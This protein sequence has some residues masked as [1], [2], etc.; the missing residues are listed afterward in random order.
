MVTICL[1]SNHSNPRLCPNHWCQRSWSGMVLWWPTRPSTINTKRIKSP[2]HHRVLEY[3]SRK[4]RDTWNDRQVW[5]WRTKWS[6]AKANRVLPRECTGHSKHPLPT[7]REKTPHGHYPM[8]N[9]E[10]RLIIF[11]AA[12]DRKALYSQQK[13]R[14]GADSGSDHELLIAKFRLKLK[15]IGKTM[16]KAI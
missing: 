4:S 9:V 1:L 6:R 2:F 14:L 11:F 10:I 13:M 3:K 16:L 7:T 8:V 12:K 5:H 15:N